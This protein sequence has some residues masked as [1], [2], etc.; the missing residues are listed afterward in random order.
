MPRMTPLPLALSLTLTLGCNGGGAAQGPTDASDA[1]SDSVGD[2]PDA[3][4]AAEEAPAPLPPSAD[5]RFID[6]R[7][8][9]VAEYVLNDFTLYECGDL[10]A[11]D[12]YD[13]GLERPFNPPLPVPPYDC[14]NVDTPVTDAGA[15]KQ[16]GAL[17][18]CG[19]HVEAC[20]RAVSLDGRCAGG[21]RVAYSCPNDGGAYPASSADGGA[22]APIDAADAGLTPPLA[23]FEALLCCPP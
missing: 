21:A 15:S 6:D 2:A 17:W 14:R 4:D 12:P 22:C 16:H 10:L 1:P 9:C 3:A 23:P 18:C 11:G 13:A 20:V 5:C 7:S 8:T 19:P